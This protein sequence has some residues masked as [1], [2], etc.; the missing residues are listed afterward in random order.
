VIDSKPVTFNPIAAKSGE[1]RGPTLC[2][3]EATGTATAGL[4]RRTGKCVT[5]DTAKLPLRAE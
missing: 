4:I 1:S 2:R 3:F 5:G